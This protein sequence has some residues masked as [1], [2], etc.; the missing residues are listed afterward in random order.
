VTVR[1]RRPTAKETHDLGCLR[2]YR[3][4]I[5]EIA[6]AVAEA[7]DLH[8]SCTNP[9]GTTYEG[10]TPDDLADMPENVGVVLSATRPEQPG[11]QRSRPTQIEVRLASRAATVELVEPDMLTAGILA[12]IRQVCEPRRRLWRSLA[13]KSGAVMFLFF[14]PLLLASAWGFTSANLPGAKEG[15]W[16]PANTAV[17]ATAAALI[18]ASLV[19]GMFARQPRVTVINAPRASR[20]TYWQRTRDGWVVGVVTGVIFTAVGYLL[21]KLT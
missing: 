19:V 13:P 15:R 21:G 3:E 10:T 12:R 6:V 20:P 9:E 14:L 7:G 1:E 16:G 17:A 18:V 2:L 11:A 8:I 5:R 4:E